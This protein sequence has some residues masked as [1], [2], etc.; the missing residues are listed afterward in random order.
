MTTKDNV[1]AISD[2]DL[3][4]HRADAEFRMQNVPMRGVSYDLV[5]E[6]RKLPGA[7]GYLLSEQVNHVLITLRRGICLYFELSEE[8]GAKIDPRQTAFIGSYAMFALAAL[9]SHELPMPEGEDLATFPKPEP[10]FFKL[11]LG[12]DDDLKT[13]LSFYLKATT[14]KNADNTFLIETAADLVNLT[15][16]YFMAL[17][18]QLVAGSDTHAA[19][20]L[21]QVEG[22]TIK[23][24]GIELR[25]FAISAEGAVAKVEFTPMLPEQIVGNTSAKRALVRYVDRLALFDVERGF[26]PLLELGG[27]PSTVLFDGFPGTG[28]TSLFRMA[29]TRLTE[30]GE[31][32][33]L[34]VRFVTIDPGI[35][36]EYYGRTGK[37]LNEKLAIVR[38]RGSLVLVFFDDVDLLLLSRGDPGM[39]GADKDVLNITMQFLD[40]AFTKHIGNAQ[41][42][43]ATNEPT[44]T[45]SA[46]RQRFHQREAIDGPETWEDYA[47]LTQ[48]KLARQI[49]HNLVQVSGTL[50]PMAAPTA[51][52]KAGF[53]L[54]NPFAGKKQ[55][56]WQ[57]LGE[58]CIEFKRKDP[59][60]T[61]RPIE[62]V[63][64]KLFAESADFD[65]PETWYT[66]PTIFMEQPYDQKVTMLT[67]LYR[68]I[69]G[70]MIAAE[71]EQYFN[72]E[73]RYSDEAKV[74]RAERL[75][76]ELEA[77][78]KAR[79]LLN[80][81]SAEQE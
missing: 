73:Q 80:D 60:F 69:T 32:T 8:L 16:D 13:I 21:A 4:G 14:Q 27:L 7:G 54:A 25:G 42:Y 37:L 55:V 38:E 51:A 81:R 15:R 44:A 56:S 70:E 19:A 49:K 30:R 67:G 75:A 53:K 40:G 35:K 50:P 9:V 28:K 31:Q 36:D 68:P 78:I 1:H 62:S 12:A 65:I 72:S 3:D 22:S 5:G 34:P 24:G 66:D 71:L 46:L 59:R 33:G 26:N 64:Q 63:T 45:D 23:V 77:Q 57:E 17:R 74:Q 20:L 29:M 76:T 11:G 18:D 79:E 48:I 58:L 6:L 43:A 2:A 41:T 61:G 47:R 10:G 52:P 39:G